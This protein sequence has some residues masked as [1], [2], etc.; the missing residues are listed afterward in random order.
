MAAAN[1]WLFRDRVS[2]SIPDGAV[3]KARFDSGRGLGGVL[4]MLK[5]SMSLLG[6]NVFGGY[7]M[8][9]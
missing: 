2:A 9:K 6:S 3:R 4:G 5:G 7:G 8:S 1:I